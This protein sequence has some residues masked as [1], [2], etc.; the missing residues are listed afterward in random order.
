[1]AKIARWRLLADRSSTVHET[2]LIMGSESLMKVAKLAVMSRKK[3][4]IVFAC[5]F[6]L[7]L[8]ILAQIAVAVSSLTYSWETGI[9]STG[10]ITQPG[11]VNVAP[12][13][14]YYSGTQCLQSG[15][16]VIPGVNQT[17]AHAYGETI[18]AI[19]YC[20]YHSD[21]DIYNTNQT[22]LYFFN[23]ATS[24]YAYRY[25]EMNPE[26]ENGNYPFLT[27]RIVKTSSKNCFEYTVPNAGRPGVIDSQDGFEDTYV[28]SFNN[29]TFNGLLGIPRIHTA[30]DATTYLYNGTDIP[31][32]VDPEATCGKRCVRLYAYRGLGHNPERPSSI[33]SCEVSVS[34]VMNAEEAAMHR[35]PDDMA[36]VAASSIALSGR[37]RASFDPAHPGLD[38]RQ[39]QMY[40]YG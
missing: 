35:L 37:S 31:Q 19:P 29:K 4:G 34:E 9:D 18:A 20:T 24:E 16:D 10:I 7:F 3:P 12:L 6:W 36:R 22:C 40:S 2:E 28:Y 17:I 27:N 5:L 25:K 38:W 30:F 26:D 13:D 23:K 39:F 14:C 15:V 33:F 8:N 11:N 1:M 32:V 21:D